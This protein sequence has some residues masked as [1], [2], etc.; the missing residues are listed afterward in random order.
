MAI[1]SFCLTS[2]CLSS[3]FMSQEGR[4][5]KFGQNGTRLAS[6]PFVSSRRIRRRRR[7]PPRPHLKPNIGL[8]GTSDCTKT[9]ANYGSEA[10]FLLSLCVK[11]VWLLFLSFFLWSSLTRFGFFLSVSSYSL[12]LLLLLWLCEGLFRYQNWDDIFCERFLWSAPSSNSAVWKPIPSSI[13]VFSFFPLSLCLFLLIIW[14][15]NS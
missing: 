10:K 8:T 9:T 12:L 6:F 2:V 15:K 1:L 7:S 14:E 5:S 3:E 4:E 11:T 13:R